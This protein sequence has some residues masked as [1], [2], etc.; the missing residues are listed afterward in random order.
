[1]L[2]VLRPAAQLEKSEEENMPE[3]IAPAVPALASHAPPKYHSHPPSATAAPV[4]E[5]SSE[6]PKDADASNKL[7]FD[8]TR[9]SLNFLDGS[10]RIKSKL[11]KTFHDL[12]DLIKRKSSS[13]E[14]LHKSN[15]I[16]NQVVADYKLYSQHLQLLL[17]NYD[18][19]PNN[20]APTVKDAHSTGRYSQTNNLDPSNELSDCQNPFRFARRVL[21]DS[22]VPTQERDALN[23]IFRS[24]ELQQ[25]I[26]LRH[27]R[28]HLLSIAIHKQII[29]SYKTLENPRHLMDDNEETNL[30]PTD[31]DVQFED[32]KNT[33]LEI[34]NTQVA[35]RRDQIEEMGVR[36]QQ[37][38]GLRDTLRNNI[39]N[40]FTVSDDE[41]NLLDGFLFWE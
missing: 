17:A 4:P 10:A 30:E 5:I 15:A 37:Q 28:E 36:L 19:S 31:K 12:E 38:I 23:K 29:K 8:L 21:S 9:Q 35:Q 7:F 39:A 24:W 2:K 41:T 26:L 34:L 13:I 6:V 14:S 16:L 27:E 33:T 18:T 3:P 25:D 22:N 40:M 20:Q 11:D 32:Q 1:M